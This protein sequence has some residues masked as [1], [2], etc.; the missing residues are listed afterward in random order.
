MR[1]LDRRRRGFTLVELLVVIAIIGILVALLLPAIQAAREAARRSECSN[2]M[3]QIGIGL[4]N[5]H[6][7]FG[8]LPLG[9]FNLRVAWPSNGSNWRALIL[10][11]LEQ[12]SVHDQLV[13][14]RDSHFMAG[15]SNPYYLNDVLREMIVETYVCPSSMIEPFDNPHSWSNTAKGLNIHYVGNQGA[16][17]PVPGGDPNA[18]TRDCGH[19]WSCNNGMLVANENFGLKDAR[20]GTSNVVLV[21]EQSGMIVP[22]TGAR[23]NR[24]SNYYGGWYGTRHDRPITASSCWDLWQT[25]TSC[26]RFA[27]NSNIIQTG[28][29][30]TMWRNNTIINSEHPGGI[31]AV[32]VDG[33]V[34][35]ITNEID[36]VNLKRLAC[37]YDGEPVADY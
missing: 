14:G 15:N 1:S 18:G 12:G 13:F 2:N 22:A 8:K 23:R 9:T 37:R 7:T 26:V 31:H 10:P 4:Q 36:F 27:P 20:D 24:T 6:D 5:Y 32:L 28:A 34:Q 21:F 29:T 35:F 33:S 11:F 17:R 16:A 3:K 19:G 30:D 25:G